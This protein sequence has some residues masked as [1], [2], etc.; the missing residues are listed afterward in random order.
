MLGTFGRIYRGTLLIGAGDCISVQNVLVKT[1]SGQ[2]SSSL[3][4]TLA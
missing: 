3:L 4:L 1:L 2:S